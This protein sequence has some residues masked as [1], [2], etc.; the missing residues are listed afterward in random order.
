MK[1]TRWMLAII[2][3]SVAGDAGASCVD[4]TVSSCVVNGQPGTRECTSGQ[5]EPCVVDEAPEPPPSFPMVVEVSA[6]TI[7]S[8]YTVDLA[9]NAAVTFQAINVSAGSDPV[10]HL[11]D[12][13]GAEVKMASSG[14]GLFPVRIAYTPPANAN[15]RLVVRARSNASSGTCDIAMNDVPWQHHVVFAG[16]Q[17][18]LSQL[19]AGE[20][21]ETVKVPNGARGTHLLFVLKPN[22]LGIERRAYGNGTAGA[23]ALSLGPALGNRRVVVGVNRWAVPG[24]VRL[25]RNDAA[26]PGHDV[27]GDGLGNELETALGL[28]SALSG[29]ATGPDGS[30]FNCGL[31]TDRRDTDGDGVLD[32]WEVLGRRDAWPHQ[33][34]PL[35]G[36]DPRHK[37]LFVEVDFMQRLPD[38]VEVKMTPATARQFAAYYGDRIGVVTAERQ[39]FRASTLRNPDGK[40]GIRAHLDIGVEPTDPADATVFGDWGGHDVVP[41]VLDASGNWVGLDYRV[42]WT[43][44]LDAARRGIFRHSSSPATGGGS[45]SEDNFA[46]SAGINQPWVLAHESGHAQGIGHSGPSHVTGDVDVNCKPNYQSMMNYAFQS[47]PNDVGFSDGLETGPLNNSVLKERQAVPPSNASY[48]AILQN[49]FRYYVDP[50]LGHVD[51]NRDGEFASAGDTVRAYANYNPTS[52]GGCEFTRYNRMMAGSTTTVSPAIAR[53]AGRTYVFWATPSA[54]SYKWT[55]SSLACAVPSTAPCAPWNGGGAVPIP[56]AQ[57]LDVVRMDGGSSS[58]LVLVAVGASGQLLQARLT[59]TGTSES[60]SGV[61][62]VDPSEVASGEPSVVAIGACDAVLAYKTAAGDLRTRR[63]NCAGGSSWLVAEPGLDTAGTALVLA[64]QASPALGRGYLPSKGSSPLL[65]GAFVAAGDSRLR[66]YSY[67]AGA[68]RW[69]LSTDLDSIPA[70]KGRP[71]MAW[72]P[73]GGSDEPGRLYLAYQRASDGM[74]RW[75]WSYVKVTKDASGTVISKVGR[76][77]LDTWFDNVWFGGKGLDLLYEPG[78]D[79]N[80]RAVS[81]D[82]GAGEVALRPKADGIQDM[83]YLNY[84]DWQVQRLGLCCQ[85]VNPGGTVAD[86][87][88]CPARSCLVGGEPGTSACLDGQWQPCTL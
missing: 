6:A 69:E 22:G 35:Y 24:P 13:S 88:A 62:L 36:A 78:V 86:P 46:F 48:L 14:G 39:L 26:I 27:D 59:L 74:Y 5:W 66:V 43:T 55:G 57:G 51:W 82:L 83:S 41:A 42:A 68:G 19:R 20:A 45:N 3:L 34:L 65:L 31:A 76:I 61:S 67:D 58:R 52:V 33:P 50:A 30:A 77:G 40:P 17:T 44:H 47:V 10:L 8:E 7:I 28:C 72:V 25:V 11:L 1:N 37:D 87:V 80:L 60:W 38:E 4:G 53:V 21:L 56:G 32:L 75:M 85:V 64:A 70:A 84:N 29:L 23:G 49:V 81:A 71:A 9:A 12:A 18:A 79:T 15:Y 54:I 63:G 16:W 2:F 73:F